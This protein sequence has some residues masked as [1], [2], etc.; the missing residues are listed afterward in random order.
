MSV[1]LRIGLIAICLLVATGRTQAGSIVIHSASTLHEKVPGHSGLSWG[2]TM[3]TFLRDV[4]ANVNGIEG[5][6]L[7]EFRHID[8]KDAYTEPPA[9]IHITALAARDVVEQGRKR[10]L[11]FAQIEPPGGALGM[12]LLVLINPSPMPRLLDIVD[13]ASDKE[14]YLDDSL[15]LKIARGSDLIIT[16]NTHLN[17]SEEFVETNA[18]FVERDRLTKLAG[19]SSHS[20]MNC[21]YEA[22][23]TPSFSVVENPRSKFDSLLVAESQRVTHLK[24]DCDVGKIPKAGVTT[25]RTLYRWDQRRGAFAA[26]KRP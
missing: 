7:V 14:I 13:V 18:I 24:G 17:A 3:R 26:I 6:D 11:V 12:A 10:L 9:L 15:K 16:V 8:G 22:R 20:Y 2:E 23:Q 1:S 21:R 19:V 25:V 4:R 5:T